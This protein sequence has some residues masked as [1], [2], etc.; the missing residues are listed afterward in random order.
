MRYDNYSSRR[1]VRVY[2]GRQS[3][4]SWNPVLRSG[5]LFNLTLYIS[6]SYRNYNRV[7]VTEMNKLENCEHLIDTLPI[8]ATR[9]IQQTIRPH[10]NKRSEIVH[11]IGKRK[12]NEPRIG[13]MKGK[14][15]RHEQIGWGDCNEDNHH[16][17]NLTL[18]T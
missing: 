13:Q 10:Q 11:M 18:F 14:A 2:C 6:R 9:N 15:E 12:R 7:F 4:S 16:N 3:G 8:W 5:C 1:Y 17:C